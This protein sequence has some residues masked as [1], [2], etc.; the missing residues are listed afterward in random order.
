MECGV[1]DA[2]STWGRL[3]PVHWMRRRDAVIQTSTYRMGPVMTADSN[4]RNGQEPEPQRRN[5]YLEDGLPA[6][7]DPIPPAADLKKTRFSAAAI[8]GMVLVSIGWAI[9]IRPLVAF[10]VWRASDFSIFNFFAFFGLLVL[11]GGV[12]GFIVAILKQNRRLAARL[13]IIPSL[14]WQGGALTVL[15][16]LLIALSQYAAT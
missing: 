2:H 5:P 9:A 13:Y 1:T 8:T 16:L 10:A 11:L 3:V 14:I 6:D 12:T 7:Q 15:I 4:T